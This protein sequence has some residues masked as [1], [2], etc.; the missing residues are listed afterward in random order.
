MKGIMTQSSQD[1][2]GMTKSLR[3]HKKIWW[4]NEEVAEAVREKKTK[5]G[6][7][8]KENTNEAS[9]EYKKSRQNTKRVISSAKVKNQK[10]WANDLNDSESNFPNGKA[11]G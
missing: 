1:I 2:C 9:T 11:D 8:K 7:W 4:W 3:R 6:K 10:E 5:Y